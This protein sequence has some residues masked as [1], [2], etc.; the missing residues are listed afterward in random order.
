MSRTMSLELFRDCWPPQ[1]VCSTLLLFSHQVKCPTFTTPWTA[2]CRTKILTISRSLAFW[3]YAEIPSAFSALNLCIIQ[4]G[5]LNKGIHLWLNCT[6]NHEA[7]Y[8]CRLNKTFQTRSTE[9]WLQNI[10]I[11]VSL[12]L[13]VS[14]SLF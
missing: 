12:P 8:V 13:V 7:K 10:F 1:G 14:P 3:R 9:D 2:A 6:N 4:Y 5:P 11:I